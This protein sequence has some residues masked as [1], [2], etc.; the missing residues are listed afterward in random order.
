[1][2]ARPLEEKPGRLPINA[3]LPGHDGRPSPRLPVIR[4]RRLAMPGA[5]LADLPPGNLD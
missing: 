1:L 2:A 3:K 5:A 4:L